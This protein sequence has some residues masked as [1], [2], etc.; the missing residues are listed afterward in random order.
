MIEQLDNQ[1]IIINKTM[2]VYINIICSKMSLKILYNL[3]VTFLYTDLYIT[4]D[5][6]NRIIIDDLKIYGIK[7]NN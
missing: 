2:Q 3:T 7:I 4:K 5:V 6:L 1:K